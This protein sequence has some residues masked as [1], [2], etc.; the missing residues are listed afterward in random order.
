MPTKAEINARLVAA[1]A[2]IERLQQSKRDIARLQAD[3]CSRPRGGEGAN[4]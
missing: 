1:R 2:E 3:P 4:G